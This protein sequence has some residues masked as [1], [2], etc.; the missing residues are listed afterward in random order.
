MQQ[1][2]WPT[3]NFFIILVVL[4]L[5]IVCQDMMVLEARQ[6]SKLQN[7]RALFDVE[8]YLTVHKSFVSTSLNITHRWL[9]VSC[10]LSLIDLAFPL[11][12]KI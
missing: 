5:V 4:H 9:H 2:L 1:T 6:T 3:G 12:M 10:Q 8:L 11:R 7:R